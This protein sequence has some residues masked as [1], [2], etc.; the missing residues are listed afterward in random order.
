MKVLYIGHYK[1]GTGWAKAALDYILALDA[2]GVDVVP[3]AVKL[4]QDEPEI[5]KRVL[6]LEEQSSEGCDVVIQH[7]L[8]HLM[9]YNGNFDANIGLFV[10]ETDHFK[11][12]TWPERLNLMDAVMVPNKQMV[13]ACIKS[14]VFKPSYV[15]PHACDTSRYQKE[16]EPFDIPDL[17][18][19]FIFYTIGEMNKRKNFNAMM[20]AFHLEFSKTD[21]VG[22]IIKGSIPGQPA[23]VA[24]STL[25]EMCNQI[26]DGLK[27]HQEHDKY[28][29]DMFICDRLTEEE[30]MRLH[31]TGDCFV[32]TAYGEAWGIPAFDAMGMGNSVIATAVG[33]PNDYLKDAG[34]LVGGRMEGCFGMT[35]TFVEMYH[36]DEKWLEVDIDRLRIAMRQAYENHSLREE[37]SKIG[38]ER[39]YDYS[40]WNVGQTMKK[41]ISDILKDKKTHKNDNHCIKELIA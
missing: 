9:D 4:N 23:H 38:M 13:G 6:D 36:G 20:K 39:A 17:E 34:W 7:V 10:T 5:P 31:T 15:V 25:Q 18:G 24:K 21:D 19:K 27:I 26:K 35:N 37:K 2:A 41:A 28:L 14:G 8:P 30:V 11:N 1:E 3:R 33:G 29:P 12:C 32:S 16:Y 40:Y 22:M